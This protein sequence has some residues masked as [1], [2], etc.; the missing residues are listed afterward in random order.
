MEATVRNRTRRI[1]IALGK[2]Q[3]AVPKRD[4]TLFFAAEFYQEQTSTRRFG[5]PTECVLRSSNH[6][7]ALC[8]EVH[9]WRVLIFTGR[10]SK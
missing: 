10:Q 4:N 6:A 5:D 7:L 8:E 1:V 9:T 3:A 2:V